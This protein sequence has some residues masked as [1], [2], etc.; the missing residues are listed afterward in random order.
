MGSVF[1]NNIKLSLFGESH[2]TA[3]GCIIDGFPY[4]INI[5][6]DFIDS[7]ME[8]RSA[9]NTKLATER[10]EKDKAEI[11]SGILESK[12][13]G[14]PIA[15]IITNE[16]KRSTDYSNLKTIPRPSHSDYTAMLRYDGFNDIRGGGHFSGRLTAPLVFAGALAK[17][18][19]KEKFDINIAAHIKQ[20]YNIKDKY[21]NNA[22]PSYEE[23]INNYNKEL[24]VFDNEAMN[25]MIKAVEEAKADKDSLGG[26]ITAA[27]FNIPAG[28]G[29]PF[30]LSIESRISQSVFA[31]PAVKGIDFGLGFDFV[32][33]KAS[34][35]NDEYALKEYNNIK[36]VETK[37]NNNGG[38]LGGISNGMP[39]VINTVIKPTP[40]I[41]KEQLTLNMETKE[42]ETLIIKGRH[43]PCIAVR[44]VPVIEA[45]IAVSILDLCIDMKGKLL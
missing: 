7:E 13:T 25:K 3:I 15:A 9:K 33:Y 35:C 30:Y 1:G 38:I 29:D 32:N 24:S 45:A 44:A 28:F 8:R 26:I 34:E 2:G 43:D 42:E 19:L 36:I 21:P 6:N 40:S 12:S 27:V 18:A 17:L 20:I 10:H 22:F 41:S 11:L 16:N 37:T 4:G 23:F 14:M 39:I 5:D 31:V